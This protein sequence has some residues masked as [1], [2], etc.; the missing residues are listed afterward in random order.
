M[1]EESG[2]DYR[3]EHN[4]CVLSEKS[5]LPLGPLKTPNQQVPGA[6]FLEGGRAW[7]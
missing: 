7:S 4:I 2:F 1:T 5:G 6:V 3:L